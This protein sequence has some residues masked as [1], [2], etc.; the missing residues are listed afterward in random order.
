MTV[1]QRDQLK[2]GKER[3]GREKE[4]MGWVLCGNAERGERGKRKVHV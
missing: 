2:F 1:W 3:R 4:R